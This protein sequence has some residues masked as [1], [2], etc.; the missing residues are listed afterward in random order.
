[1]LMYR[2]EDQMSSP[3][4]APLQFP[5]SFPIKTLGLTSASFKSLVVGIVERHA[6]DIEE[7]VV[8]VRSSAGGKYM[9]VTVTIRASSRE[10]LD[11]IYQDLVAC[12]QV[13]VA[14]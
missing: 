14:L 1:M 6:P 2:D 7:A 10:Q 13:L 5:C 12:D 4:Q 3:D 8:A 9:A 11:A